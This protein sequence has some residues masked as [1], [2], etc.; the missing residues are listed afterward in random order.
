MDCSGGTVQRWT[1]IAVPNPAPFDEILGVAA[2]SAN[3]A[4]AV[5]EYSPHAGSPYRDSRSWVLHWD[6]SAWSRLKAPTG[7]GLNA[8]T[9]VPGSKDVWA[10]GGSVAVRYRC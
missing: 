10:V 4:W 1:A 2:R 3:D 6:G 9:V 5:G 8:V 7:Q